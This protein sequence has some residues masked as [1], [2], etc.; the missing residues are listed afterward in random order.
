MFGSTKTLGLKEFRSEKLS[1]KQFGYKL[2]V[3][4]EKYFGSTKN[5]GFIRNLG[6]E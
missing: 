6:F 2:S 3:E 1:V 5:L 4:P